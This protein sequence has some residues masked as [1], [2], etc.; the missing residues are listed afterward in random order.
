VNEIHEKEKGFSIETELISWEN[1][2]VVMR[3]IVTKEN[4]TR[5]IGHAYEKESNGGINRTSAL[6][7]CETSAI[8]RALSA[9]GYAGSEYASANEVQNAIYQQNRSN[10]EKNKQEKLYG[11]FLKRLDNACKLFDDIGRVD[12]YEKLTGKYA[13]E[14]NSLNT[15]EERRQE[16]LSEL[17]FAL[18]TYTEKGE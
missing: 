11:A 5:F 2:I 12:V 14:I 6:E 8:G 18:R 16:I 10:D 15:T 17:G 3:A 7:N 1:G 9:A 13:V 4:G